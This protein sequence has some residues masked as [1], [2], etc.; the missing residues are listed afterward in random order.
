[1]PDGQTQSTVTLREDIVVSVCFFDLEPTQEALRQLQDLA[2]KLDKIYRFRELIL[3][4][5]DHHRAAV[6]PFVEKIEDLRIFVVRSDM[7]YYARRIVA[8]EEAIGDVVVIANSAELAHVDIPEFIRRAETGNALVLG[9]RARRRPIRIGLSSP[10]IALGRIA[11]FKVNLDDL[12]TIAIPRTLLNQLLR[13]PEPQLALRFPP[14]DPGLP[15]VFLEV[16]TLPNNGHG[17]LN[18]LPRRLQLLQKLLVYLAPSLLMLVALTSTI[19]TALGIGYAFYIIGA[20]IL[21]ET[22]APGW[23]TTSAMLSLSATFMGVSM[24]GLSLG[25]QQLLSQMRKT[26]GHAV[27]EEINRIDLFGKV[28]SD[29]NVEVEADVSRSEHQ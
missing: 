12:Q 29:L 21:V 15:L 27:S 17:K 9:T 7:G 23:L 11:G 6:L 16:E 1:M 10:I 25:V 2:H 28:A 3:V 4:V 18:E 13:H 26:D 8:A 22:L 20:W 24:L 19:L 5:D 14:R